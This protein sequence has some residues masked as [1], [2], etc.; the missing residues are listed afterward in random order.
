MKFGETFMEYLNGDQERHLDKCSHVEYK[1]LKKVLKSC[2]TSRSSPSLSSLDTEEEQDQ[3]KQHLHH[4]R[5]A[6]HHG[7]TDHPADH[8][9]HTDHPASPAD[10]SSIT[11]T[12]SSPFCQCQSCPLCD[13]IFFSELMKEASEVAGFFS[14]RVRRLL[15]LHI[16]SGMQRY[17]V[18]LRHFFKHDEQV[19]VQEGRMLIEYVAM[20]ALAIR[21]LLK[22]YDKVHRSA[23]GMRFKSKMRTEHIEILQ[24]PWLIELGAFYM[25]FTGS[26]GGS[27]NDLFSRVS[28]E[29][30]TAEATMTL[31]LSDL[32]KLEY[33]LTCPICLEIVFNPYALSCG[34]LFCKL[35]ACT[36]ASVMIFQGPKA[37]RPDSKCPVCREVGVYSNSIHM[38]ELDLLLKKRC[39]EHW[40]ERLSAERAEM[41]KQSKD[42]WDMQTKFM[43]GF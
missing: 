18:R 32:L 14:S 27:P 39:K 2:R 37:A 8:H 3:Q 6:G 36:A 31:Q 38:L 21:K 19:M 15:H 35:C 23:N 5:P 12:S 29:L 11:T 13:Q 33:N 34:H 9:G 41:V 7:D 10:T 40:K 1:R 17:V 30:S 26:N 20:N 16:A 22:K 28:Y 4:H 25:N 42:Y 43:V 24:S